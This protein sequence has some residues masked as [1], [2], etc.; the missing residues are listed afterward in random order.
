M[1][2]FNKAYEIRELMR[3][4][5]RKDNIISA[6]F[7][8]NPE[9]EEIKFSYNQ[10][11]DDN[12]YSDYTNLT[13]VNGYPVNCDTEYDEDDPSCV[14]GVDFDRSLP[15]VAEEKLEACRELVCMVA[16]EFGYSYE[17]NDWTLTRA[18]YPPASGPMKG[19]LNKEESEYLASYL[20]R[21]PL[22]DKWFSRK[23]A[24]W[25]C[26]YALDWGRFSEKTEFKIFAKKGR[27]RDAFWY[28][29]H[30]IKGRLPEPV[31]SFFILSDGKEDKEW[32]R[33]YMEFRTKFQEVA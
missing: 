33:R 6:F 3:R 8:D 23:D 31:E 7:E 1:L 19:D 27:M 13:S 20:S 30:V 28:A 18:S 15:R 24:K 25:A 17:D 21:T 5:V 16:E 9:I 2:K 4:S 22:P 26:Y 12:N 14:G 11:Y 32:L 10:E 29:F